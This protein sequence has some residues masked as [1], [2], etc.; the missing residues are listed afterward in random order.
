MRKKQTRYLFEL[1]FNYE[2]LD[3]LLRLDS[4]EYKDQSKCPA[5]LKIGMT[6]LSAN[7]PFVQLR[8]HSFLNHFCRL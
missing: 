4:N 1:R 3:T 2:S 7:Q 8:F 5:F 6:S